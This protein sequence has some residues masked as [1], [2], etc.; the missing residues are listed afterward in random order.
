M[1]AVIQPG[2]NHKWV[3][4][5]DDD[6]EYLQAVVAHDTTFFAL[7]RLRKLT[8]DIA[9]VERETHQATAGRRG[10]ELKP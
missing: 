4:G 7:R 1:K 2:K 10:L 3:T 8:K 5:I 6:S 9:R